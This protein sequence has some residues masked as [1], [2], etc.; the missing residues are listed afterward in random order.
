MRVHAPQLG[1]RGSAVVAL[2]FQNVFERRPSLRTCHNELGL[3][4]LPLPPHHLEGGQHAETQPCQQCSV[5]MWVPLL[6][7]HLQRGQACRDTD[8]Q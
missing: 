4:T 2:H 7:R 8:V 5:D 6:F 1:Q 3:G